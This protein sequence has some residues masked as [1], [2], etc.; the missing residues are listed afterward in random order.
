MLTDD[1]LTQI[2]KTAFGVTEQ[3]ST[4]GVLLDQLRVTFGASSA[5]LR[6]SPLPNR[7]K[8]GIWHDSGADP[9]TKGQYVSQWAAHDLWA[10]HPLGHVNSTAG[11]C[12]I[13]S[14]IV[15]RSDLKRSCFYNEFGRRVGFSTVMTALVEDGISEIGLPT[16]LALFRAEGLPDFDANALRAFQ[17][18]Q[19]TLRKALHNFWERECIGWR[20]SDVE[21]TLEAFHCQVLVLRKDG[22]IDYRNEEARVSE[23]QGWLSSGGGRLRSVGQLSNAQL[24]VLLEQAYAGTHQEAGFLVATGG[25]LR[26]G[27]IQVSK[28]THDSAFSVHWPRGEVLL[29]AHLTDGVRAKELRLAALASRCGLTPAESK[30]LGLLARSKPPAEVA[31]ALR[32]TIH[33]VRTHVKKIL[34]KTECTRMV[35]LVLLLA[36]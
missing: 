5:F 4:W 31:T 33:T 21:Q 22:T 20:P 27:W 8:R 11:R 23:K 18:L 10:N 2:R 6:A 7:S 36:E 16:K 9:E 15:P 13:G 24:V 26:T 35:D 28:I 25:A 29:V 32:I 1:S 34:E 17:S 12:F 19:P 30:V 14:S 3:H